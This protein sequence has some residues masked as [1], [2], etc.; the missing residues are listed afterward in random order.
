MILAGLSIVNVALGVLY[1]SITII[2]G[3]I[4]YKRLLRHFNK[5]VPNKEAYCE[6][7]PLENKIESGEVEFYFT[8]SI[9]KH[10]S[11]EILDKHYNSVAVLADKDFEIGQHIMRFDTTTVPNGHYFYQLRT[12]NQQ[13]L[14]KMEIQNKVN[15]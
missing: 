9:P 5:N 6:L 10:V 13:T 3:Y 1:T 12:G 8:T 15:Q 7:N 14:R 11:F 4:L 2:V